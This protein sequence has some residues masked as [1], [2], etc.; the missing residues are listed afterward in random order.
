[1]ILAAI[2]FVAPWVVQ[3]T[4]LLR[5]AA[6]IVATCCVGVLLQ[7]FTHLPATRS[8]LSVQEILLLILAVMLSTRVFRL[9]NSQ[10]RASG[11][12]PTG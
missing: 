5:G 7:P 9:A 4:T 3:L 8:G 2:A 6:V 12:E 10:L 11:Q 1:V